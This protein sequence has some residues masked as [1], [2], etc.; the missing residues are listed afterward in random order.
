[1][2]PSIGVLE[3]APSVD[4]EVK[5]LPETGTERGEYV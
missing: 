5:A 2:G 3:V 4:E 1:M